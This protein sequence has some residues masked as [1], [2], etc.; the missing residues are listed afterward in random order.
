LVKTYGTPLHVVSFD[1]LKADHDRF[2]AAFRSF[3]ERTTLGTSY[4]TNP[5]P[6]VLRELHRLG[7]LAEVISEFELWLALRLGVPGERIVFNGPGKPRSAIE[8]AVEHG[9]RLINA[10]SPEE[11][12]VVEDVCS[13]RNARQRVGLR[14]T[15]SVGWQSQFGMNIG[16]GQAS[17]AAALV[18]TL[19]HVELAG[20]HLHLGNGIASADVYADGVAELFEFA[21]GLEQKHGIALEFLD[22]GGGF[23][24]PTVRKLDEW[25]FRAESLGYPSRRPVPEDAI[26]AAGFARAIFTRAGHLLARLRGPVQLILEPGRAITSQ[27][28]VLLLSVIRAKTLADGERGLILDGGKNI[29][30]PLGWEFHEIL[31][32]TKMAEPRIDKQSLFGPLC[33]PGDIVGLHRQLPVLEP[34]DVVAIMDAGAYFLPNQTNFSNPRPAVVGVRNGSATVLRTRETFE[35]IVRLDSRP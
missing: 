30:M 9:V 27:S 28:Q 15:T 13:A 11:I 19:P 10:D 3:H 14:V 32:A 6:G 24:V 2:L 33:H 34:G 5:L 25:D 21:I 26:D 23:G 18:G 17:A 22:L 31:P 8:L 7:T 1:R 16:T 29:T 20:L 12:K 4:K 35:D